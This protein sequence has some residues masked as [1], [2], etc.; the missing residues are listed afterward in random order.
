MPNENQLQQNES[1][2]DL[3]ELI[4]FLWQKKIRIILLA[5]ILFVFGACE[6]II[7]I[8]IYWLQQNN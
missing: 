1:S 6:S 7:I 3:A 4:L 5:A 8:W 2:F